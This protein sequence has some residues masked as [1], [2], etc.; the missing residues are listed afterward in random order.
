MI[1][2]SASDAGWC[3]DQTD[4]LVRLIAEAATDDFA[5]LALIAALDP[6]Y[7]FRFF[8]WSGVDFSGC[9]VRGF[10]F[11]GANLTG[12]RFKGTQILGVRFDQAQLD[13]V[14][15]RQAQDWTRFERSWTRAEQPPNGHHLPELAVFSD[16][17]FAPELV[18]IPA[19]EFLMGS[20]ESDEDRT[21]SEIPRHQVAI[22]RRF[23][24]GRH[25]V[26]FQEYDRF[27]AAK[28]RKPPEDHGWSRGR[29]PVINVSW[30]GAQDYAG[31]L[32]G[33]TGREYR[34][35]SEAEWEYACRAGTLTRYWWGNRVPT[36]KDANFGAYEKIDRAPG[37]TTAV[38]C[39]PPNPWGLYDT[40][41]NV[42]EWVEDCWHSD[43]QGAAVD[44]SAWATGNNNARDARVVRGGAWDS[45]P[46]NV[47]SADCRGESPRNRSSSIGFRLA[48]NLIP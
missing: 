39:Y 45:H 30:Q 40:A 37:E 7:D 36:I 27:C 22:E 11:T 44:G 1:V 20:P 19:G 8:D 31:W 34:L 25:L 38:G 42:W 33:S 14:T 13:R 24:L 6:T 9:D 2:N 32:S 47:R 17:P 15:L 28:G 21:K 43:Y 3:R 29:R 35:P 48:T 46:W 16:A 10:D 23:G 41:G 4:E 26:T 12:C 5:V 18:V